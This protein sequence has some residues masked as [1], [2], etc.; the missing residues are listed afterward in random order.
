M[1]ATGANPATLKPEEI[2]HIVDYVRS[3]PYEAMSMPQV[4]ETTVHK[5]QL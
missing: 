5:P 3:L 4:G 2:W 1:P